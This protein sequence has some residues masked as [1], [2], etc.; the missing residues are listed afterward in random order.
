[1]FNT[2]WT[3]TVTPGPIS[4][5]TALVSLVTEAL[6]AIL[7]TFNFWYGASNKPL[8]PEP[9]AENGVWKSPFIILSKS[10]VAAVLKGLYMLVWKKYWCKLVIIGTSKILVFSLCSNFY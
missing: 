2:R 3:S 9:L 5:S 4:K 7:I 1:M 8:E 10:N 6:S